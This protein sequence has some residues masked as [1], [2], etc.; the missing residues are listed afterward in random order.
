MIEITKA[1]EEAPEKTLP[2]RLQDIADCFCSNYCK[3]PAMYTDEE[4]EKLDYQ[5]CEGCPMSWL[6]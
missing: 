3:Y 1:P 2:Q 5:P 4:W 6:I